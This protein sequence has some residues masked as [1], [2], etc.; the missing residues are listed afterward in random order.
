M[1]KQKIFCKECNTQTDFVIDSFSRFHLKKY[2]NMNMQEYYDKHMKKENEG[3]CIVCGKKTTFRSYT[4]GYAEFCSNFCL[5]NSDEMSIRVSESKKNLDYKKINIKI[6]N[7]MVERYGVE[8]ALQNKKIKNKMEESNMKKYG[9]A[10]TICL[11]HVRNAAKK[12][13]DDNFKE[14]N[15][16]RGASIHKSSKNAS[17]KRKDTVFKKYGVE[18]VLQDKI[19]VNKSQQTK[20]IKYGFKTDK[21]LKE[22]EKYR[23]E[24]RQITIKEKIFLEKSKKCYYTNLDID[25]INKD[26]H[27]PFQATIDHKTSLLYGFNNNIPPSIIGSINNLCFCCRFVNSIKNYRCESEFKETDKY[28]K[29]IER[30]NNGEFN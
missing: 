8:H 11:P 21:E 17:I 25:H 24:V 9:T 20:K 10:T 13:I 4:R 15:L 22:F 14:V 5:N 2:H 26:N 6:K 30:V 27:N 12:A 1:T 7:T 28:K 19:I 23:K 18:F 16:K 29:L 3:L